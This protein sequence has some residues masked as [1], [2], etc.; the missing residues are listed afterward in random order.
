M[1]ASETLQAICFSKSYLN[2]LTR[3][4]V[5]HGWFQLDSLLE[6]IPLTLQPPLHFVQAASIPAGRMYAP[7]SPLLKQ[8]P[9]SFQLI[10]GLHEHTI[11]RRPLDPNQP[12]VPADN[13]H[14]HNYTFDYL[15]WQL[16]HCPAE[17][18]HPEA[19]VTLPSPP[20]C[21]NLL[22]EC[23]HK[24]GLL[25]LQAPLRH[26]NHRADPIG[27]QIETGPLIWPLDLQ[28]FVA[29]PSSAGLTSAWLHANQAERVSMSGDRLPCHEL[30]A[31]LSLLVLT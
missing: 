3:A 20:P 24:D 18:L 23:Q 14:P 25:R 1:S 7:N 19:L 6:W 16:S 15:S 29:A 10:S 30:E 21:L 4:E 31:R 13:S 28:A 11:L 27:W 9:Y 8:P 22:L 5:S 2:W 17:A 26:W 12:S